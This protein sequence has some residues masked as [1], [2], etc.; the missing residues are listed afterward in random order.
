MFT[1]WQ[2]SKLLIMYSNS[3]TIKSSEVICINNN[4][5]LNI[6]YNIIRISL[7]V[8]AIS[9]AANVCTIQNVEISY[10]SSSSSYNNISSE[11]CKLNICIKYRN[12]L[13]CKHSIHMDYHIHH[14]P[15]HYL[16]VNDIL[17]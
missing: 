17:N 14:H 12:Q 2:I 1:M 9:N 15:L 10:V 16:P 13:L 5:W 8:Y 4:L 7:C 6:I 11:G 3:I